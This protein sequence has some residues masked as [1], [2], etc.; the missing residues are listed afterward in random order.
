MSYSNQDQLGHGSPDAFTDQL[1]KVWANVAC[2]CA[3]GARMVIRF[4][5]IRDRRQ[6]PRELLRTSFQKS[7]CGWR[8][9]TARSAGVATAGRRQASQFHAGLLDPIEEYDFYARLGD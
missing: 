6:N 8:L 9:R 7:D 3:D 4:G 5:G 1:G 2:A